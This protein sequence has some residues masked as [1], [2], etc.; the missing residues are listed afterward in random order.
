MNVFQHDWHIRGQFEHNTNVTSAMCD[1]VCKTFLK[2]K[3]T[4]SST[5]PCRDTQN[6]STSNINLLCP[7]T[8]RAKSHIHNFPPYLESTLHHHCCPHASSFLTYTSKAN[9]QSLQGNTP[10]TLQYLCISQT[11]TCMKLCHGFYLLLSLFKCVADKVWVL[12]P[13]S[14][15]SHNPDNFCYITSH[16]TVNF[17]DIYVIL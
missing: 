2:Q 9:L 11:I 17:K 1:S 8:G 15:F 16:T 7:F 13:N 4:P 12:C 10:Y 3:T 6:V 14:T 5:E